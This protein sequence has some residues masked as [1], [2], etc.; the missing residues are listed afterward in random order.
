MDYYF[1]GAFLFIYIQIGKEGMNNIKYH[2]D[3]GK[4][5]ICTKR[6]MEEATKGIG[7]RDIKGATKYF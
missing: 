5:S 7:Q 1:T 4:M 2:M 6:M 3:L